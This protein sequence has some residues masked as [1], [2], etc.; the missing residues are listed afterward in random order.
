M[1]KNKLTIRATPKVYELT[2][3]LEDTEPLVWRK[4]LIHDFI[5]LNELH[6]VIQLVMGWEDSHLYS[7]EINKKSYSDS[8]SALEMDKINDA[9][10]TQLCDVIG[11]TKKFLY[12]YDF[13]DD[14]IHQIEITAVLETD[15][16][17][18]Y[19]ICIA[20]ENACPP[21]NCGGTSGFKNL[22][23]ILAGKDSNEKDELLSWIGGFYNPHTFDPNFVNRFFLWPVEDL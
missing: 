13:G 3:T 10:G 21:E 2:I 18:N 20:G 22:K 6:M 5:E 19:P 9:E 16:R 17:M 23:A 1:K 12:A 14:W 4:V 8:E 7:F 15:A 11:N